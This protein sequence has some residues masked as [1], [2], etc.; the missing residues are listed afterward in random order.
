V[1]KTNHSVDN[2]STNTTKNKNKCGTKKNYQQK[3]HTKTHH[4]ITDQK[5][6]QPIKTAQ[7]NTYPLINNTY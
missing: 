2:K 3:Q 7:K 1:D 6:K 4:L 5:Q